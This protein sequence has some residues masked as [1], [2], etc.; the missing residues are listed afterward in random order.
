MKRKRV[1]KLVRE[2]NP[3]ETPGSKIEIIFDLY[4]VRVD[5]Y[6]FLADFSARGAPLHAKIGT[7]V[8]NGRRYLSER[9]KNVPAEFSNSRAQLGHPEIF[10][11]PKGIFKLPLQESCQNPAKDGVDVRVGI[12]I[13]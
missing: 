13:L 8:V 2:N 10:L 3:G 4:E 7:A 11:V 5:F 1:K 12:V 9:V 6:R